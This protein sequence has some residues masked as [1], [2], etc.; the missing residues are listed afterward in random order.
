MCNTTHNLYNTPHTVCNTRH[1]LC[2]ARCNLYNAPYTAGQDRVAAAALNASRIESFQDAAKRSSLER[3]REEAH[4]G[5]APH[6]G[7]EPKPVPPQDA[8]AA[9]AAAADARFQQQQ[10]QQQ[11]QPPPPPPPPQQVAGVPAADARTPHHATRNQPQ[12]PQAQE[13]PAQHVQPP[14]QAPAL[15]PPRGNVSA[16]VPGLP[17][18]LD[19]ED[20]PP[21]DAFEAAVWYRARAGLGDVDA[22]FNLAVCYEEGRGVPPDSKLACAWYQRA[23]ARGDSDA[24]FSLG[25]CLFDGIGVAADEARAMALWEEA[26][27]VYPIQPAVSCV[28]ITVLGAFV[29]PLAK[30]LVLYSTHLSFVLIVYC[31]STST[32]HFRPGAFPPLIRFCSMHRGESGLQSRILCIVALFCASSD[33]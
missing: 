9:A 14:R 3:A 22:M 16:L 12:A 1:N 30:S 19:D 11:Q 29:C 20:T 26:S 24:M 21:E 23:A 33:R 18:D 25:V 7:P 4:S 27:G 8:R 6:A 17:A 2:N 31:G 28:V 13:P 15:Q 10:Q 32:R 5:V